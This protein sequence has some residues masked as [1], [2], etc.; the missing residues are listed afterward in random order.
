MDLSLSSIFTGF[1]FLIGLGA[2]VILE[3]L[4]VFVT[5]FVIRQSDKSMLRRGALG[6][7]VD[8]TVSAIRPE[9]VPET[10]PKT[11]PEVKSKQESVPS[12]VK[13]L[14]TAR[15]RFWYYVSGREKPFSTLREALSAFPVEAAKYSKD[16]NLEYSRLPKYLQ[17]NIRRES[18]RPERVK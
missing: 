15:Q 10:A 9:T 3:M 12:A 18:A 13:P 16:T 2:G 5:L 4:A 8:K 11:V 6:L 1:N 17:D 7:M 14:T